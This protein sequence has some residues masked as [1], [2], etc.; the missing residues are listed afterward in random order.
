MKFNLTKR[1]VIAHKVLTKISNFKAKKIKYHTPT[2]TDQI[3]TN[4]KELSIFFEDY[5]YGI[6]NDYF[7]FEKFKKIN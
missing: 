1:K 6:L 3:M 2:F 5:R 4:K 7:E